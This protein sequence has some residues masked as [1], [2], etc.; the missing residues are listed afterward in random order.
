ML[1]I[2]A[3]RYSNFQRD[4]QII[5]LTTIVFPCNEATK[6]GSITMMTNKRGKSN[7]NTIKEKKVQ[8][9]RRDDYNC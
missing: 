8:Q 1:V 9:K 7:R 6:K 2:G 3:G 5:S 4:R